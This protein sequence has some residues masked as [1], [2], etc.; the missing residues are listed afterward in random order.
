MEPPLAESKRGLAKPDWI[1]TRIP[2]GNAFREVLEIK[3]RHGLS[4]VCEEARCPNHA[5]CWEKKHAT[6]MILGDRCTRSCHFCSVKKSQ[7]PIPLDKE[8]PFRVAKAVKE[9][10]LKYC[11]LTSVTR[12]DLPDGGAEIFARTVK[13]TKKISPQLI[14]ELL[15]PDFMGSEESF[16][17]VIDSGPDI[18]GHNLETSSRMHLKVRTKSNY[19]RSLEVLSLIKRLKP[20]QK[21]KS[22][23]LVGLGETD[24]EVFQMI[25]DLKKSEIDILAIGQY[26]KPSLK[27]FDVD[28]Y[29]PPE[30]FKEFEK[31]A[32]ASGI[33]EVVAGPFVRS[34]YRRES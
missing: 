16:K 26:L 3:S 8:E 17:T 13:E 7:G 31:F 4:T 11:V 33:G 9:L 14:L 28:R 12:D 10:G 15:V 22:A 20:R 23:F 24:E 2:G 29:V 18:L 27:S 1:K 34:S 21:T 6:F 5:E 19:K 32:Q 30:R 25:L